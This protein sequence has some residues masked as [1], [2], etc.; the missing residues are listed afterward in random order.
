MNTTGT[1]RFTVRAA[2][3]VSAALRVLRVTQEG[4]PVNQMQLDDGMEAL[5]ILLKNLQSNG[6][7]LWTYQY[8]VIPCQAN[9]YIYTLGPTGADVTCVR[10]LR[11]FPGTYLRYYSGSVPFDVPLRVISR[12]EYS[13]FGSKATPGMPNTVYYHPGIDIAGGRSSP[14]DGWGTLYIYVNPIDASRSIY[15]NFQRPLYDVNDVGDELDLPSEW[16]L[17]LKWS[18]AAELADEYEVSEERIA[19]IEKKALYYRERIQDWS[20]EQSSVTFEPDTMVLN[21]GAA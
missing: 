11:L 13:Q 14:S 3:I 8:I 16:L 10:P 12:Q 5:N 4:A 21:R 20:T 2:E 18:L 9:K 19:R 7:P 17:P 1:A 6:L 15:G